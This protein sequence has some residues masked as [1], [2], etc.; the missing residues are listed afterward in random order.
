MVI[1]GTSGRKGGTSGKAS[2]S[3]IG[4]PVAAL[5]G[6]DATCPELIIMRSRLGAMPAQ[7][8]PCSSAWPAKPRSKSLA[9]IIAHLPVVPLEQD[10]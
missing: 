2:A 8:R 4:R 7:I 3:N 10:T 5:R 6:V 1:G 9:F